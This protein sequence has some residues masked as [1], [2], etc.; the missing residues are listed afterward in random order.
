MKKI[1]FILILVFGFAS[2]T[3]AQYE[4]GQKDLNIGVGF[5]SGFIAGKASIP[6]ISLSFDVGI[7]DQISIGGYFGYTS[8]KLDAVFYSWNYTYMIVGARGAYHLGTFRK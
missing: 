1:S 5:G 4:K 8:S 7:N 6:P 3:F 2:F